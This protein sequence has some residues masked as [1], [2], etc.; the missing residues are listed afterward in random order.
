MGE[1]VLLLVVLVFLVPAVSAD[2]E[3]R[4]TILNSN[5]EIKAIYTPSAV[6]LISD[7]RVDVWCNVT[8]SDRNGILDLNATRIVL[9]NRGLSSASGEPSVFNHY[10]PR[11]KFID[12]LDET[13][14]NVSA[15]FG[16]FDKAVS[17]DWSCSVTTVD[18]TG[19]SDVAAVDF[20]VY[21][22]HCSN[23]VLDGGEDYV[24]CG[25]ERCAPCLGI[26]G[27]FFE[28]M[29]GGSV[30]SRIEFFSRAPEI[31]SIRTIS[32]GDGVPELDVEIQ[33]PSGIFSPGVFVGSEA[34]V[35]A[36]LGLEPG[37]YVK[38]VL[39]KADSGVVSED[40]IVVGVLPAPPP[41]LRISLQSGCSGSP[42]S[43]MVFDNHTKFRLEGVLLEFSRRGEIVF[44]SLTDSS[45]SVSFT[46]D[47][48]GVYS[49]RTV[50]GGY[51]PESSVLSILN[52]DQ[53]ERL[54]SLSVRDKGF[55]GEQILIVVSDENK[56]PVE[57]SISVSGPDGSEF[58]FS[59]DVNGK[60]VLSLDVEGEYVISASKNGYA[61]AEKRVSAFSRDEGPRMF[62]VAIV[63]FIA[64][65]LVLYFVFRGRR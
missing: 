6:N 33:R 23:A 15:L 19:A 62:F 38:R 54:L 53:S 7:S 64:L 17:G 2:T 65:V 26:K 8:I 21:A 5:P 46:P 4:V 61:S 3:T 45:G 22:A 36:E 63:F 48:S 52:C 13:S 55:V 37:V 49:V 42:T 50:A 56:N 32:V 11:V 30:R 20:S 10:K 58:G 34:S 29:A 47:V 24:D 43:V 9:H 51:P 1:R 39:I 18:D 25:S 31:M 35:S 16:L 14:S 44:S 60:A 28:V 12:A 27:G 40:S 57:S 41:A 59:T